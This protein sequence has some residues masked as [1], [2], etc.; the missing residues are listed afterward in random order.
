MQSG[1]KDRQDDDADRSR[2]KRVTITLVVM[3]EF[4]TNDKETGNIGEPNTV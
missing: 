2:K 3:R 1:I 4:K